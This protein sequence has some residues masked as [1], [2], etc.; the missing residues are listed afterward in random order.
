MVS[1]IGCVL[2]CSLAG[3]GLYYACGSLCICCLWDI[4]S[5]LFLCGYPTPLRLLSWQPLLTDNL[6]LNRLFLGNPGTGKTSCARL[7]GSILGQ[8]G[9]LSKGDVILKNASDFIGSVLGASEQVRCCVCM[10]LCVC[11]SLYFVAV[12]CLLPTVNS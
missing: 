4:L 11:L 1:P 12:S 5:P 3:C 2:P 9:L 10:Y 8:L 7:Y 6:S